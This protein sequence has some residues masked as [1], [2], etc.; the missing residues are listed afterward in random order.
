MQRQSPSLP[1]MQ[2]EQA[3]ID[4]AIDEQP[5]TSKAVP[6]FEGTECKKQS[7]RNKDM[8]HS[9]SL[10]KSSGVHTICCTQN[11]I[12]KIE[13]VQLPFFVLVSSCFSV[14]GEIFMELAHKQETRFVARGNR[15]RHKNC[16]R[17]QTTRMEKEQKTLEII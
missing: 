10:T 11:T 4:I 9:S 3:S 5:F 12:M 8:L 13:Y 15:A 17:E 1:L 7:T 16:A 2:L 14:R 6:F